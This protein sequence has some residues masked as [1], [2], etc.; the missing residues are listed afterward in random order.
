VTKEIHKITRNIIVVSC[1][2]G[3]NVT[4]PTIWVR[5]KEMLVTWSGQIVDVGLLPERY[6]PV[7]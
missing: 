4:N 7:K 1:E 6:L 5:S 2:K 3:R